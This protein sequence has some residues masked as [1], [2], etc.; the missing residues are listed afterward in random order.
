MQEPA[1]SNNMDFSI[2][3]RALSAGQRQESE[4]QAKK[5]KS[6]ITGE[7][8]E[9]HQSK[10]VVD[11]A[12]MQQ[13]VHVSNSSVQKDESKEYRQNNV[14]MP[15]VD[16]TEQEEEEDDDMEPLVLSESEEEEDLPEGDQKENTSLKSQVNTRLRT[17]DRLKEG[18]SDQ[19]PMEVAAGSLNGDV[20]IVTT[21]I[22]EVIEDGAVD[23]RK[24]SSTKDVSIMNE[25]LDTHEETMEDGVPTIKFVE[26]EALDSWQDVQ[27]DDEIII[28]DDDDDEHD[29]EI[30]VDS[31][32]KQ[33][34]N[35]MQTSAKPSGPRTMT[36]THHV[37]RQNSAV[38]ASDSKLSGAF[39]CPDCSNKIIRDPAGLA[40]HNQLTG[41][42]HVNVKPLWTYDKLRVRLVDVG[43]SA[44]F[45][46]K[47]AEELDFLYERDIVKKRKNAKKNRIGLKPVPSNYQP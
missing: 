37:R 47:V 45:G 14:I 11:G 46:E 13:M 34:S 22:Q 9:T 20:A 16:V 41:G 19:P 10:N 43:L 4:I 27:V 17:S 3:K 15:M 23:A 18:T 31:P 6:E 42:K 12:P 24:P 29:T 38:V 8:I 30:T 44:T 33:I 28:I 26:G 5:N 36:T 21:G 7:A 32:K 35:K 2:L 39:M 40:V 25:S 1:T